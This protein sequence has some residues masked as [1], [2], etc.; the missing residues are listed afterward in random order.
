MRR[1]VLALLSTL[2]LLVLP[3][4]AAAAETV[5][6]HRITETM[7]DVLPCVGEAT[8]TV[9]YNAVEHESQSADGSFHGT[10]TQTGTFS[11]VLD[12]GGSSSGRFTVWDGFNH[13]IPN[14]TG[15]F[16]LTFSGTVQSGV[17]AGTSWH[18][19]SHFTG[20]LDADGNPQLDLAKVAF[21]R[22]TC[23]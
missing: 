5:T 19:V 16:T 11:A 10:A 23:H 1:M 20:S 6:E 4:A 22:F 7:H 17:G 21:D 18:E 9:T 8:I 3:C 15:T 14:L 2:A 12:A 13:L